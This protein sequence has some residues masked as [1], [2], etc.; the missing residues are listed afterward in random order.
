MI[1]GQIDDKTAEKYLEINEKI[2][3]FSQEFTPSCEQIVLHAHNHYKNKI[4]IE[5]LKLDA[6]ISN[7]R[8][9][10]GLTYEQFE[11]TKLF[12]TLSYFAKELNEHN[13]Q[14]QQQQH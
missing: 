8:P 10:N 4:Q 11:K 3:K 12:K 1:C 14:K 13:K 2:L 5:K 7:T 9:A 6:V